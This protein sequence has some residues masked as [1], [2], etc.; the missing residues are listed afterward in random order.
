MRI[1][2]SL[3]VNG[4]VYQYNQA[5]TGFYGSQYN[6]YTYPLAWGTYVYPNPAPIMTVRDIDLTYNGRG[7]T[8][9]KIVLAVQAK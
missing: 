3:K 6:N 4:I 2:G 5:G 1:D 7:G 9:A 8:E